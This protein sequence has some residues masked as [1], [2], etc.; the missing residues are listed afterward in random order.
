M[1]GLVGVVGDPGVVPKRGRIAAA[2][3]RGEAAGTAGVF[4]FRFA[5]EPVEARR[6]QA[7][8]LRV[9][10]GGVLRHRRR[11]KLRFL[12]VR[13]G[14]CRVVEIRRGG[15][16]VGEVRGRDRRA[17]PGRLDG[18]EEIACGHEALVFSPG[19]LMNADPEWLDGDL[20]LRAFVL[21]TPLF[22]LWASHPVGGAGDRD[23]AEGDVAAGDRFRIR[24]HP[25]AAHLHDRAIDCRLGVAGDKSLDLIGPAGGEAPGQ[26]RDQPRGEEG[27][28]GEQPAKR[29]RR[30]G[31]AAFKHDGRIE[32]GGSGWSLSV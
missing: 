31:Q 28:E 27:D 32:S 5:G 18:L 29:C 21:A 9:L 26:S 6:E 30:G 11:R 15:D 7:D 13:E 20:E 24:H 16:R 2:R 8:P 3:P 23:H 12:T 17:D 1:G 10:A 14:G 4:P 25:A 22:P 19:H